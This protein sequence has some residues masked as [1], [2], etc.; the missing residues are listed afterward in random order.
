MSGYVNLL[1]NSLTAS[2]YHVKLVSCKLSGKLYATLTFLGD[3]ETCNR[4]LSACG[5]N[6]GRTFSFFQIVKSAVSG[7][8]HAKGTICPN[9]LDSSGASYPCEHER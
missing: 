7:V 1:G 6:G 5:E 4:A 8:S 9:K 3:L 2:R